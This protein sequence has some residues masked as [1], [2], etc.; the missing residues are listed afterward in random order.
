MIAV[1]AGRSSLADQLARFLDF[2]R[3]AGYRYREEAR[4]LH[5]LDRFLAQRSLLARFLPELAGRSRRAQLSR[6]QHR[7]HPEELP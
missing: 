4:V 5:E 1:W 7:I 6:P 2:K 3:A